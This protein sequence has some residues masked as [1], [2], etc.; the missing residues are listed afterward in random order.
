[1]A[2]QTECA[3]LFSYKM[4][5]DS[6][7]PA[8]FRKLGFMPFVSKLTG[9]LYSL[10]DRLNRHF[11]YRMKKMK[12]PEDALVLGLHIRLGDACLKSEQGVAQHGRKCD[13]LDKYMPHVKMMAKKYGYKHIYLATDSNKVLKDTAKYTEYNWVFD[14]NINHFESKYSIEFQLAFEAI[15]GYTAG[16]GVIEDLWALA[17]CDGMVGKFTSNVDRIAYQLMTARSNGYRPF[18]SMDSKWCFDH[19]MKTGVSDFGTFWC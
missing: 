17:N 18:V 2:T 7:L 6:L 9:H 11:Q 15:D 4:Q 14:D 13:Q 10:S 8:E 16:L 3:N 5:K 19:A 12:F 1:M